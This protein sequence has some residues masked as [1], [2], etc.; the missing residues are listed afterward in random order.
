[1]KPTKRTV[2]LALSLVFIEFTLAK[3]ANP[4]R[5]WDVTP[6]INSSD[7][8]YA[9][10]DQIIVD[11]EV[12]VYSGLALNRSYAH[13][14]ELFYLNDTVYLSF[15]S[16][17]ID[18]DSMGQ[19]VWISTSKDDG[20][21]WTGSHSLLPAAL[22]PNQTNP[23]NFSYWCEREIAQRAWQALTFVH[24]PRWGELYAIG[25]SASIVCPGKYQAAGRIARRVRSDGSPDG[26]PCWIDRN[27]WTASQLFS[28]TIY[29][30][31]FGMKTCKRA[32]EIN[33]QLR[34]P[35]LAPAWSSWLYNHELFG[36]DGNHSMQEQTHAVWFEDASSPTGGYWQ[37]FWRDISDTEDNSLAVWVEY[38]QNKD[39]RGWYPDTLKQ[40]GNPIYQ[41][42]IPDGRTKQYLGVLANN[43]DRYLISNPRSDP[44]RDRQP[45]TIA[46][47]RGDDQR[48]TTIGVLRTNASDSTALGEHKNHGFSYPTAVQ[49][50][51]KL[52]VAYSENKENIWVSVVDLT[53]L[54]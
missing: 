34:T 6:S 19:E 32:D 15:S 53:N 51:D 26:E 37:R 10:W 16:A 27:N 18:E 4:D 3:P 41:T 29:G 21:T 13:H 25:Q 8:Y 54:P 30:T 24:L 5:I 22:L 46:M 12:K 47:S 28:Q 36:A 39:G 49:V 50:G 2:S 45:L 20:L 31:R 40:Y 7:E 33:A 17:P 23:R 43:G 1:M 14:P 9:G 48:Y 11:K 38:N 44:D 52:L 35:D 42:N